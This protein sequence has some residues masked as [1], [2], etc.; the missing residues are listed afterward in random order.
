MVEDM[1]TP[2]RLY[3]LPELHD[4]LRDL[5]QHPSLNISND[6]FVKVTMLHPQKYCSNME[7]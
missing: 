3:Q 6:C 7:N 4:I 5:L 2:Q 1:F